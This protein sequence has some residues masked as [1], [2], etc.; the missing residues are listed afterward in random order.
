VFADLSYLI[1]KHS[2]YQVCGEYANTVLLFVK[3]FKCDHLK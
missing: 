3:G 2:Q 1:C